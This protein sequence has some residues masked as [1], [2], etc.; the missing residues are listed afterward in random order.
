[1]NIAE[2]RKKHKKKKEDVLE[3]EVNKQPETAKEDIEKSPALP[4][5]KETDVKVY[6]K[7][8]QDSTNINLI[9]EENLYRKYSLKEVKDLKEFLCFK[10]GDEEYAIDVRYV[11]EVI[12]NKP[13]T[14]I[15]KTIDFILGVISIRGE[16]LPVFDI[17]KLLD[18]PFLSI[19]FSSKF[20]IID[21]NGE[22]VSLVVDEITQISKIATNDINPTPLNISG[23]K[24][25]FIKGVAI[26][27]D[28][29]IRLLDLEKLLNF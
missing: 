28:K 15:P 7:D 9:D 10:L 20:I 26:I 21:F 2:I 23:E 27:N 3:K 14:E 25:E 19:S 12:K 11:K 1:M 17:K 4:V 22:I 13:V 5:Q 8:L 18:I 24:Q 6:E 16:I 29:M